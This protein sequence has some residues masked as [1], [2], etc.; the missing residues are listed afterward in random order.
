MPSDKLY[1]WAVEKWPGILLKTG[2][3]LFWLACINS[4]QL[5]IEALF[6]GPAMMVAGAIMKERNNAESR[7]FDA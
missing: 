3:A 4:A 1:A 6:V 7:G 2:W 5:P